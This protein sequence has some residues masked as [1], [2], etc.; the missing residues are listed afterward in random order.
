[1]YLKIFHGGLT[2]TKAKVIQREENYSPEWKPFFF[3]GQCCALK[4][5]VHIS[6]TKQRV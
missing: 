3:R 2:E 5:T 4:S 6:D 1:M